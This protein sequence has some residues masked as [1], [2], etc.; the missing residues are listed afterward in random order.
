MLD[1]MQMKGIEYKIEALKRK[2]M[3]LLWGTVRGFRLPVISKGTISGDPKKDILYA[4][5][6]HRKNIFVM[7][8]FAEVS[9]ELFRNAGGVNKLFKLGWSSFCAADDV[10]RRLFCCMKEFKGMCS[11]VLYPFV[12]SAMKDQYKVFDSLDD[13][14]KSSSPFFGRQRGKLTKFVGEAKASQKLEDYL[15]SLRS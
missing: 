8:N 5:T 6:K 4:S 13:A 7:T 3:R 11:T 15:Y 9:E 10:N 2:S 14:R 12:Y 1:D